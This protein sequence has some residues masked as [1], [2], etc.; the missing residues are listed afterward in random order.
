M[1]FHSVTLSAPVEPLS[2]SFQF[3]STL[4]PLCSCKRTPE[5]FA[6]AFYNFYTGILPPNFD[7][8]V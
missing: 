5:I 7:S 8:L 1:Y 3:S 6:K 4:H 2:K